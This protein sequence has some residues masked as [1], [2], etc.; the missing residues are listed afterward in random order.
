[1]YFI[2]I[3]YQLSILNS[4]LTTFRF[5][6][7]TNLQVPLHNANPIK[8]PR[9]L[10]IMSSISKLPFLNASCSNSIPSDKPIPNK[11]A[12]SHC[13][14]VVCFEVCVPHRKPSRYLDQACIIGFA[15]RRKHYIT[16]QSFLNS[17]FVHFICKIQINKGKTHGVE[18]YEFIVIFSANLLA[19]YYLT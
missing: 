9:V 3:N 19:G 18:I 8:H 16:T 14:L 5:N 2:I 6:T 11:K 15:F 17:G 1:M 7:S 10:W 12:M 4:H 13:C